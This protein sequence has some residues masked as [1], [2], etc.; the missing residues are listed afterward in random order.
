MDCLGLDRLKGPMFRRLFRDDLVVRKE[1]PR[2]DPFS[3][4]RYLRIRESSAYRRDA[5]I[6]FG[7]DNSRGD[8]GMHACA[9]KGGGIEPEVG[10]LLS[11]PW[12]AMQR[13]LK[14]G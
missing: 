3:Q 9:N 8:F 13:S 14:R 5:L 12:Q 7:C 1:S 4:S 11:G 6:L 10:F 2:I